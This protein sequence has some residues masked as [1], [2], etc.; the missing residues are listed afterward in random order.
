M[1]QDLWW[2]FYVMFSSTSL[3]NFN[4]LIGHFFLIF[5]KS[6]PGDESWVHNQLFKHHQKFEPQL[7]CICAS[8]LNFC[9][10]S[11]IC[12]CTPMEIRR[13]LAVGQ[14]RPLVTIIQLSASLLLN[15]RVASSL[16]SKLTT[17]LPSQPNWETDMSRII[18][19][20]VT[21][22]LSR[23]VTLRW[24]CRRNVTQT[25]GKVFVCHH[26]DRWRKE[27]CR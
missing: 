1:V 23:S 10:R 7:L 18:R 5:L 3:Y 25:R 21:L 13:S 4:M 8:L 17:G 15:R 27:K 2:T 19:S 20:G 22:Y 14:A 11:W 26:S 24:L 16:H 12:Y 6:N 9:Q